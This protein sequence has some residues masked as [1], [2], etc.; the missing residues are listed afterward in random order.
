MNT[1][2]APAVPPPSPES[3]RLSASYELRP[4]EKE[5]SLTH[6]IEALL[7]QPGQILH[8]CKESSMRVMIML[9][10][11][12][13]AG[14]AIF[15]FLLGTFSGGTQLW[16]APVKVVFGALFAMLICLPSL[17]I[18]SAMAGIEARFTQVI[19][20]LLAALALSA[21]L[22][23]GFAPV[24]WIFSQSTESVGF[25][26]FLSLAFWTISLYFG[27]RL[28]FAAMNRSGSEGRG[29][30]TVWATIFILVT[31][32]LTTSL[33]PIIGTADTFL[34]TEKKFFLGHWGSVLGEGTRNA[35][36]D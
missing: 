14:L 22:L 23:L 34:P 36:Y 6:V 9:A 25:M 2:E 24:V 33:R 27:L 30:L 10:V 19:G 32:Q 4:F 5:P 11:G 21:L 1:N 26:G 16:A 29:Y 8:A 7:K 3:S 18:F 15:G 35:K 17:Y 20:T 13:V 31:L 12:A 28:L